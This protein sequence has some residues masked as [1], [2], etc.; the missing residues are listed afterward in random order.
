MALSDE[1]AVDLFDSAAKRLVR[2]YLNRGY[3]AFVLRLTEEGD[4]RIVGAGMDGQ[5]TAKMLRIAADEYE[6][7]VPTERTN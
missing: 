6:R 5:A 4:V 7:Q 2:G 1:E 3:P